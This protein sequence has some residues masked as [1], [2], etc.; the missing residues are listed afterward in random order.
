MRLVSQSGLVD[1]SF[2]DSEFIFVSDGV[3]GKGNYEVGII[4][5]S[6]AEGI[7]LG[8]YSS[9]DMCVKVLDQFRTYAAGCNIYQFPQEGG[10]PRIWNDK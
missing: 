5:P 6:N 1:V 9:Q 7:L 10:R 8:E 2:T 3:N 4:H